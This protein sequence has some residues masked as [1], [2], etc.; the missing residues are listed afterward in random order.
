MERGR[1]PGTISRVA[2][3]AVALACTACTSG[4]QQSPQPRPS[5][6]S[7]VAH[8][9]LSTLRQQNERFVHLHSAA[10]PSAVTIFTSSRTLQP[11]QQG[12]VLTVRSVGNLMGSCSPGHPA[13]EFRITY[14]G[15]GPPVVTKIEG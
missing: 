14:R 2:V 3:L 5:T 11:G 15:A 9:G 8:P 7:P 10:N 13:V 6:A 12:P 4:L 1:D